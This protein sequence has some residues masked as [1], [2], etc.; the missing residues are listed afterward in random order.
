MKI[1]VHRT[2]CIFY[3]LTRQSNKIVQQHG[4]SNPELGIEIRCFQT[5]RDK[6]GFVGA[7]QFFFAAM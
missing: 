6:Q 1:G 4:R 7:Q 2:D 3:L 5:E